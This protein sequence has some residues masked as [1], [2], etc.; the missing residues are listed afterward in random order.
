[1]EVTVPRWVQYLNNEVEAKGWNTYD[2][3][4]RVRQRERE[5]ERGQI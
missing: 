5:E 2:K 1:M 4:L 3:V